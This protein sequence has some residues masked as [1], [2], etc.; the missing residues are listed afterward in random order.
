[1]LLQV[2]QKLHTLQVRTQAA[3]HVTPLQAQHVQALLA[4]QTQ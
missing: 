1:M 4:Q 2:I 3:A